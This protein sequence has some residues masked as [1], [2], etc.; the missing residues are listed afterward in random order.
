MAMFKPGESG[1]PAGKPKGARNKVTLAIEALLD[2]EA[3]ALTRKAIELAMGG[4]MT[5]LRL[6]IDRLAPPRKDRH[7]AFELPPIACAA[8]AVKASAFLVAA[9]A[10]GDLTPAEAA[11]L[12]KLIEGYVRA[13][14]ATDFALRLDNLERNR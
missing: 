14:E 10:D 9:V 3:E 13:L 7:V 12:G 11:E 4:D 8:D 5:A 2:G 1:N 6:C